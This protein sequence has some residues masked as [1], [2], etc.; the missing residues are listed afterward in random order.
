MDYHVCFPVATETEFSPEE[1]ESRGIYLISS[2]NLTNARI[3]NNLNILSVTHVLLV[4]CAVTSG[5]LHK[6]SL[7]CRQVLNSVVKRTD[8][9]LFLNVDKIHQITKTGESVTQK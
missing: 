3:R 9:T 7:G 4:L 1:T 6:V 5:S 2:G 8:P